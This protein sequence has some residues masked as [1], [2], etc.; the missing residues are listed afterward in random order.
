MLQKWISSESCKIE[1]QET[2]I[3]HIRLSGTSMVVDYAGSVLS[4]PLLLTDVVETVLPRNQGIGHLVA[5][6]PRCFTQLAPNPAPKNWQPPLQDVWLFIVAGD[7]MDLKQF[8]FDLGG[9]GAVRWDLRECYKIAQRPLG[10]GGGGTIFLGQSMIAKDFK[11]MQKRTGGRGTDVLSI[12][13]VAVKFLNECQSEGVEV[14]MRREVGFLA[15]TSSHPNIVSMF[16]AFC[17]YARSKEGEH[18]TCWCIAMELLS[19]GDLFGILDERPLT[20]KELNVL[21]A[22][23][24]S[25]LSHLH[26][27]R[28]VHRDVKPENILIGEGSQ[29][30]L[31]DM[32]IA[33]NLDDEVEMVKVTGS[34]GYAAP[35][36]I[37]NQT[38]NE[39]VDIFSAGC[40]YYFALTRHHPF[41]AATRD[42]TLHRTKTVKESYPARWFCN[43]SVGIKNLIQSCLSKS[44]A[45]RP[46]AKQCLEALSLLED[47]DSLGHL[48][49]GFRDVS[50]NIENSI[51]SR[52]SRIPDGSFSMHHSS[53]AISFEA[54]AE[55]QPEESLPET[56]FSPPSSDMS[57]PSAALHRPR[58]M[59]YSEAEEPLWV[60]AGSSDRASSMSS[61]SS[62]SYVR[63]MAVVERSTGRVLPVLG[64]NSMPTGVVPAGVAGAG[65]DPA[66]SSRAWPGK[67]ATG[68]KTMMSRAW[69]LVARIVP[70]SR[71]VQPTPEKNT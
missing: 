65:P 9:R 15:R 40:T 13:Q 11:A 1:K 5:L 20:S 50:T 26:M 29:P 43:I 41:Q 56:P 19:S 54:A 36:I 31:A 46:S 47:R 70:K 34:A 18:K 17:E 66:S 27:L 67:E 28:I 21:I 44:P 60:A 6:A 2:R 23:L 4:I 63:A 68:K 14:A 37:S 58:S 61:P 59:I 24:S 39:I 32:G 12:N 8:L 52:L 38:Y 64:E 35:E 62:S 48:I 16:S 55:E 71:K 22:G 53:E 3:Q 51:K 30:I 10:T 7:S 69:R 45:K 57:S 42:M 49:Y 33:A 25:A